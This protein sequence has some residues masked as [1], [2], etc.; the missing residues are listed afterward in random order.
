VSHAE[1]EM[2]RT[3][4]QRPLDAAMTACAQLLL[5]VVEARVLRV[6]DDILT[7]ANAGR[8]F[9]LDFAEAN[10]VARVMRNPEAYRQIQKSIDDYSISYTVDKL[11]ASGELQMTDQ[12]WLDISP[13]EDASASA[14]QAFTIRPSY[15]PG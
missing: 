9:L 4:L 11:V 10:A 1:V 8:L 12:E 2:V 7:E 13:V 15:V 5:D 14:S 6:Y 3:L